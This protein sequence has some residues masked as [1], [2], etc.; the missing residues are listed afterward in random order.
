MRKTTLDLLSFPNINLN[1]LQEIWLELNSITC[2]NDIKADQEPLP[3]IQVADTGIQKKNV[4][5]SV[6]CWYDATMGSVTKNEIH[7]ALAIESKYK[8]Y[9]IRQEAD[10]KFLQEE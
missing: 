4:D 8:P 6:M 3:V 5:S 7:E 9:L 1:K 10:M 2:W